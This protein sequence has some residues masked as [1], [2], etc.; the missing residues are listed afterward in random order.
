MTIDRADIRGSEPH[1][2]DPSGTV[3]DYREFSETGKRFGTMEK[4][5]AV[6]SIGLCKPFGAN[7]GG[8]PIRN[9]YKSSILKA[10]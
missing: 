7:P 5:P 1:N 3:S 2:H 9:P 10:L 4:S 6:V 8:R